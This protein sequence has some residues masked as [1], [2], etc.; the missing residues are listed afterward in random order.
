MVCTEN[1]RPLEERINLAVFPSRK[2][3][4]QREKAATGY[5]DWFNEFADKWQGLN[6]EQRVSVVNE[7]K[8]FLNELIRNR[9]A[10]CW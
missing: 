4:D 2:G 7:S 8:Y 6:P 10:Y 9:T 5:T 3:L 1:P